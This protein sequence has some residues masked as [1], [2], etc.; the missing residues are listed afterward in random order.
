MQIIEAEFTQED[1]SKVPDYIIADVIDPQDIKPK[2]KEDSEDEDSGEGGGGYWVAKDEFNVTWLLTQM[3]EMTRGKLKWN[4]I[5]NHNLLVYR[6]VSC[7][8]FH[9]IL[10]CYFAMS[11]IFLNEIILLKTFLVHVI[12]FKLSAIGDQLKY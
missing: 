5:F 1:Y 3:K 7:F 8:I 4:T 2:E 12:Y 10:S 9:N 11:A 6:S